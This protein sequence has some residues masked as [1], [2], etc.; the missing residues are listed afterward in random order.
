MAKS[1][2]KFK[3]DKHTGNI[4]VEGVGYEKDGCV[5]DLGILGDILGVRVI[6]RKPKTQERIAVRTTKLR[7]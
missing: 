6:S 5:K 1:E 7:R 4:S 3:V 2:I